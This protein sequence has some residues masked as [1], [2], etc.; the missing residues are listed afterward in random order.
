M[1]AW[2]RTL[3]GRQFAVDALV[4]LWDAFLATAASAAT[5]PSL[6]EWL[7]AAAA[8]RLVLDRERLLR[9]KDATACLEALLRGRAVPGGPAFL[10]RASRQLAKEPGS[11][12]PLIDALRRHAALEDVFPSWL[13]AGL[14]AVGPSARAGIDHGDIP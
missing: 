12:G 3:F 5:G 14:A 1:L 7:E 4:V 8:L 6:P 2:L 11:L 13:V 9:A 10:A